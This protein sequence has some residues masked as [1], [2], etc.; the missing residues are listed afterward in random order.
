MKKFAA[1]ISIVM[2]VMFSAGLV[3]SADMPG[4]A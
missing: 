1:L 3:I 4:K 2:A